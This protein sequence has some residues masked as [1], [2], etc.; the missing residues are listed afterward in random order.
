MTSLDTPVNDN[1]DSTLKDF[2]PAETESVEEICEQQDLRF[3]LELALNV[4]TPREKEV[5]KLRAGFVD[6]EPWTL[7]KV[8][9]KYGL[10]RERI[11]QIE[12]RAIRKLL[13]PKYS[14]NLKNF[15]R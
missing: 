10:T 4:L 1:G 13:H 2:I 8:G 11:R 3:Q 6:D 14:R 5:L 12:A 9:G 15:L 7:E